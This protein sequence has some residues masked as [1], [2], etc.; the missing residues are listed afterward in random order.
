MLD[1]EQLVRPLQQVVD[2]R[3]HRALGDVDEDL[4]VEILLRSDEEGLAAALVVGRDRDEL[5]DPLDVARVE[6]GVEQPLRRA[7]AQRGPA[8][9]GTR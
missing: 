4:G 6:A 2:R 1:D 7:A 9:R 3:A 5:E 8:R